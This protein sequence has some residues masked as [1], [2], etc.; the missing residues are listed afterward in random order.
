[1]AVNTAYGYYIIDI[2]NINIKKHVSQNIT[3][4]NT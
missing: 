3:M 2:G 4:S 1:M